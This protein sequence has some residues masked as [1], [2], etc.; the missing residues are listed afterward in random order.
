M[1]RR[2]IIGNFEEDFTG[3][4]TQ[5]TVTAL[6]HMSTRS[7]ANPPECNKNISIYL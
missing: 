3:Q 4:K 2:D 6:K 1:Y 7:R 5:P